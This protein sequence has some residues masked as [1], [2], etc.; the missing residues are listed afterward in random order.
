MDT[1]VSRQ[2]ATLASRLEAAR[3]RRFVGRRAELELVREALASDDPPWAVLFVHGPGGVGKSTLLTRIAEE[4]RAAGVDPVR[5][6]QLPFTDGM[7]NEILVQAGHRNAYDHALRAA[8]A[9]IVDVGTQGYPGGGR[10]HAWQVEAAIGPQTVGI[11]VPFQ[12][13]PGTVPLKQVCEI[14]H[15]HGLA[16]IVDAAAAL[17]PKENLRRFIADGADLVA[18]SGGKAIGGPQASGILCGR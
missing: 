4:A 5:I 14:A 13:A 9:R 6:D 2:P 16:V 12:N 7:P 8:G 15:R 10:T 11:A 3:R 17:P 18:Y 1:H